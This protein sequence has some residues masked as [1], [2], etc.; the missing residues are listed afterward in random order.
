[1]VGMFGIPIRERGQA[2]MKEA[3][4]ELLDSASLFIKSVHQ[5]HL[6]SIGDVSFPLVSGM[7][8]TR[9]ARGRI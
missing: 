2:S 6:V 3:A 7:S 4:L 5:V 8:D 1:M 9:E